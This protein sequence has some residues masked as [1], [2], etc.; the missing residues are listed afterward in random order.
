MAKSRAPVI[1]DD[2]T[3]VVLE[4]LK[5]WSGK[6]TWNLLIAAIKKGIGF[7]YTR[8]ALSKHETIVKEFN[9]RK[10][11]LK[12]EAGRPVSEDSRFEDLQR[13]IDRLKAEKEQL[14]V[15][16]NNYRAMYFVWVHNAVKHKVSEQML[17]EPLPPSQQQSTDD[18]VPIYDPK[19]ARKKR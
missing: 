3:E 14:D 19:R 11:T 18:I 10:R 17:N 1:S 13:Q 8:Q 6:L 2:V 4:I 12:S 7:I 9:L 5:A 16:C 15:E